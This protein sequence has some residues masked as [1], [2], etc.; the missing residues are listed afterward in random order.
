MKQLNSDPP[1][2]RNIDIVT[3]QL[4]TAYVKVQNLAMSTLSQIGGNHHRNIL[5]AKQNSSYFCLMTLLIVLDN[6]LIILL[7]QFGEKMR[8]ETQF[9]IHNLISVFIADF[10]SVSTFLASTYNT[11]H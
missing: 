6:A 2:Q 3:A 10:S 11:I 4:M 7:Q 1:P 9:F 8:K 5:S